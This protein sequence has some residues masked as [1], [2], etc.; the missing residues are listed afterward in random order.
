MPRP[1]YETPAGRMVAAEHPAPGGTRARWQAAVIR[2]AERGTGPEAAR[3]LGV[4]LRQL[5]RWV[6]WL[7]DEGGVCVSN[8]NPGRPVTDSDTCQDS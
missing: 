4:S 3:E 1:P 2:S 5:R 6:A 8:R 7:R